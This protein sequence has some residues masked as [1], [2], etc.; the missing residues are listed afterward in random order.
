MSIFSRI[1]ATRKNVC[2]AF[3][4]AVIALGLSSAAPASAVE[5][6][7]VN[8]SAPA[9]TQDSAD[10]NSQI[11]NAFGYGAA[12]DLSAWKR[13][14]ESVRAKNAA[15]PSYFERSNPILTRVMRLF[16]S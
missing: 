10:Q 15:G 6:A 7:P 11:L 16:R 14:M 2:M 13:H 8:V 5:T 9:G 4:S 3:A 1:N 12:D